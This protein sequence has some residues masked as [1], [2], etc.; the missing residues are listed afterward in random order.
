MKNRPS[1]QMGV[2]ERMFGVKQ[3]RLQLLMSRFLI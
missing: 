1:F 3:A 2:I